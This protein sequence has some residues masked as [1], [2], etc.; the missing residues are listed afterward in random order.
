MTEQTLCRHHCTIETSRR[1]DTVLP[2]ITAIF[3]YLKHYNDLDRYMNM[4]Y[5]KTMI[6]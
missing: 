3:Q 2:I 5:N 6:L 1:Q 4:I